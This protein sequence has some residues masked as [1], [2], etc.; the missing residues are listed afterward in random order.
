MRN[1]LIGIVTTLILRGIGI[2]SIQIQQQ[3]NAQSVTNAI[4]FACYA[5]ETLILILLLL[6]F[7]EFK[8]INLS[9]KFNIKWILYIVILLFIFIIAE[10]NYLA[11]YNNK[12]AQVFNFKLDIFSVLSIGILGPISEE[13]IFRGFIYNKLSNKHPFWISNILQALL[14][15]ILHVDFPIIICSFLFGLF[16]GV[17]TKYSNFLFAIII[18][19]INNLVSCFENFLNFNLLVSGSYYKLFIAII[20]SLIF[21]I[22]LKY[23]PLF[24]PKR[25]SCHQEVK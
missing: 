14:F 1:I 23:L 9:S 24:S 22:S 5:L 18:H 17:I 21:I 20:C 3:N 6:K 8:S 10:E 2:A 19:V 7:D 13:L 15:S 12:Y 16:A 25:L 4:L 11:F